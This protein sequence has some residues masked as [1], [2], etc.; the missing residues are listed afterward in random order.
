MKLIRYVYIILQR[1]TNQDETSVSLPNPVEN[2]QNLCDSKLKPEAEQTQNE[3]KPDSGEISSSVSLTESE[4]HPVESSDTK[5]VVCLDCRA[6]HVEQCVEGTDGEPNP[7]TPKDEFP[8]ELE[9]N[10]T[11]ERKETECCEGMNIP[12]YIQILLILA[13]IIFVSFINQFVLEHK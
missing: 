4:V 9:K 12:S 6:E 2:G 5:E 7:D 11:N 10:G 3:N 1:S 13:H 8:G